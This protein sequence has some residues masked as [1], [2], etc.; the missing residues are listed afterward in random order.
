LKDILKQKW[1][2]APG[3]GGLNIFINCIVGYIEVEVASCP[4]NRMVKYFIKH[5]IGYIEVEVASCP[6]NR[7][8]KYSYI[9]VV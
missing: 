6:R 9:L 5:I 3:I 2:P 4:R 7:R 1:F 8:F